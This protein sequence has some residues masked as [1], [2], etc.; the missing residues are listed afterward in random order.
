MKRGAIGLAINMIVIIILS[1]VI[2]GLG[3]AFLQS[4]MGG[5]NELKADLDTQTSN[6]LERLMM[7]QNKKVAVPLN[8]A[9][10]FGGDSHVFGV[11]I[12]NILDDR[13]FIIEIEQSK[14]IDPEE[15]IDTTDSSAESWLLYN[16]DWIEIAQNDHHKEGI[17]VSV[18][19]D[20][21]SGTYIFNVQVK[22][23]TGELYDNIKKFYVEVN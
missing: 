18:P 9:S 19:S 17:L 15:N 13:S 10:L 4:I 11:G 1:I 21:S 12:L 5:A 3:I 7:D 8:T 6:E 16:I 23:D 22:Q 14:Y 20:A 2:L